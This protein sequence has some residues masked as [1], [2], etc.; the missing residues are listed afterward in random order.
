M[1]VGAAGLRSGKA[2][3]GAQVRMA[4][5]W[6]RSGAVRAEGADGRAGQGRTGQDRTGQDRRCAASVRRGCRTARADAGMHGTGAARAARVVGRGVAGVERRDTAQQAV[7]KHDE[8]PAVLCCVVLRVGLGWLELGARH[9]AGCLWLWLCLQDCTLTRTTTTTTTTTSSA[10]AIEPMGL[11]PPSA[12]LP[13]ARQALAS[14]GLARP[15][16]REIAGHERARATD[17]S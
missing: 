10:V 11:N 2:R 4:L 7:E 5:G 3:R 1:G 13:G 8:R 17:G 16:V 6:A 15:D 12:A 9:R 14:S